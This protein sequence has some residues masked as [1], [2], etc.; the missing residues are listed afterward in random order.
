MTPNI[1]SETLYE[2]NDL[3]KLARDAAALLASKVYYFLGEYEEALSFALGAGSA[4]QTEARTRGSEEYI[5][6]I[7][8]ACYRSLPTA[9]RLLT[10]KPY[11][12]KAID[13]DIQARSEE[14]SGS[15]AKIDPRLQGIIEGIFERCISEGEF[16][17]VGLLLCALRVC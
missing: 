14:K 6:T 4:F 8:C 1:N 13:R 15:G 11:P 3:P 12:A 2:S 16:K 5:E 10:L 7:V 9:S 17:Q